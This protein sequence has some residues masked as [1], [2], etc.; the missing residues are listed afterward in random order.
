MRE[1][2]VKSLSVAPNPANGIFNL[3][4]LYGTNIRFTVFDATG[5]TVLDET[6]ANEINNEH[7]IDLTKSPSGI[8]LLKV[9]IGHKSVSIRLNKN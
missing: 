3:S 5:K 4:N 8:Y 2:S 1:E 6:E 7:T 9:V